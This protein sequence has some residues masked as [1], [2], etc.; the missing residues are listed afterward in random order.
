MGTQQERKNRSETMKFVLATI[1]LCIY[2][3]A[4]APVLQTN[5]ILQPGSPVVTSDLVETVN[6]DE[7]IGWT[8]EVNK[9]SNYTM[10]EITRLMGTLLVKD[11]TASQRSLF[12]GDD[13]DNDDNPFD[14]DDGGAYYAYGDDDAPAGDDDTPAGDDDD[15]GLPSS[16]DARDKWSSCIQP[17]R[18]QEQCGSCWA[19]GA[20]ESFSDRTCIVTGGSVNDIFSPQDL[21]SCDKSDM[22]CNGGML[23]TA[24]NFIAE[25]GLVTDSC[26]PYSSGTGQAP[27]CQSTCA[28]GSSWSPVKAD[29]SSIQ[30]W[31]N[32]KDIKNAI[33][34]NGPIEVAFIVYQDFMSYKSGVYE[35]TTGSQLG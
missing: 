33:Y 1:A 16:F 20:A 14:D 25:S 4:A 28:D 2:S 6:S 8:A 30:S 26:F 35:H 7:T 12:F 31:T 17:I 9:F 32:V 22:G 29:P 23:N 19:F 15:G 13:D 34:T 11:M 18:N 27:P 21:V 10:R 5:L 24:W 3:A